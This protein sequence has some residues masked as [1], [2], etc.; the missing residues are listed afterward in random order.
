[1]A[2]TTIASSG[3]RC[4]HLN[5]IIVAGSGMNGD[6]STARI[7]RAMRATTPA[8]SGRPLRQAA[9][10]PNHRGPMISGFGTMAGAGLMY[11]VNRRF[12]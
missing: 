9:A 12:H 6:L 5:G 2:D 11:Q 1:M 3:Y 7:T 4:Q 8:T 10:R